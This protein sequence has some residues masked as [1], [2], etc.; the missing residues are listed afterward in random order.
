MEKITIN[1]F[2]K[3]VIIFFL[4]STIIL[5]YGCNVTENK[6]NF[7]GRKY[8]RVL[9]NNSLSADSYIE[10]KTVDHLKL[11]N[12]DFDQSFVEWFSETDIELQDVVTMDLEYFIDEGNKLFIQIYD[13][14]A[15]YLDVDSVGNLIYNN[16]I[17]YT[18]K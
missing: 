17:V 13:S 1:K 5:F 14:Y 4:L 9:P 12:F 2:K 8:F 15:I 18:Q 11:Y 10:F 3:S 6:E 16:N 7:S